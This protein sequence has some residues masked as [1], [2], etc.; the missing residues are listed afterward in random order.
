MQYGIPYRVVGG[1]RF[2]DRKEIKDL[3]AYLR[4]IYQPDDRVSFERIVNVPTRG[5]GTKS[6]ANFTGWA[7]ANHLSL[8]EALEHAGECDSVKGKALAGLVELATVIRDFRAQAE[9]MLPDE[10]IEKLVQRVQYL[11][12]L[13]DGTPQGESRHSSAGRVASAS[14]R[15]SR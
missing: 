13:D 15:E 9:T 12:F 4:L 6:V 11:S 14:S 1:Q 7:A 5:V 10:L 2:Y 8:T 3:M